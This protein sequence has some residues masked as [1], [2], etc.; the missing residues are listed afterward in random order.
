MRFGRSAKSLRRSRPREIGLRTQVEGGTRE[1]ARIDKALAKHVLLQDRLG[2][3]KRMT[4]YLPASWLARFA[5][6]LNEISRTI[7]LQE[8]HWRLTQAI[9][10]AVEGRVVKFAEVTALEDE[11]QELLEMKLATEPKSFMERLTPSLK[12]LLPNHDGPEC[13]E[14]RDF[15]RGI[16]ELVWRD[17]NGRSLMDVALMEGREKYYAVHAQASEGLGARSLRTDPGFMGM[18]ND[19]GLETVRLIGMRRE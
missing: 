7:I 10:Y 14:Y 13:C 4:D 8:E 19:G 6:Y 11:E 17:R 5:S 12:V 16:S 9:A 3:P 18:L 2:E 1:L 15:S